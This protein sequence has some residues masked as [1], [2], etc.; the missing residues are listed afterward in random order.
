MKKKNNSGASSTTTAEVVL[1]NIER[2]NFRTPV[3]SGR[4][5]RFVW[6]I[7]VRVKG[8]LGDG[9]AT[10]CYTSSGL[11]ECCCAHW[12]GIGFPGVSLQPS[13]VLKKPWKKRVQLGR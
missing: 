11:R 3:P 9:C 1:R 2:R 8:G 4:G 10:E 6:A 12:I 5:R 7:P 13:R